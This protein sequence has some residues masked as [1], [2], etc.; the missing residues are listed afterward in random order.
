VVFQARK[1]R[2][3]SR[4]VLASSINADLSQI[5]GFLTKMAEAVNLSQTNG[6]LAQTNGN[7]AEPDA[8]KGYHFH[9]MHRKLQVEDQTGVA[10]S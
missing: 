9:P 5:A 2:R 4:G 3:T 1:L 10:P 8:L 7:N 6:Q